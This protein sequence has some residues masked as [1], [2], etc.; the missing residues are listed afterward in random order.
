MAILNMGC[1]AHD[2][3]I[4]PLVT[5]AQH[6]LLISIDGLRPDA[7]IQAITPNIDF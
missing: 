6:V 7:L 3:P 5:T 1:T 4:P 2:G